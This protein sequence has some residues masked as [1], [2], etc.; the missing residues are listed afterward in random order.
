MKFGLSLF[1]L[2]ITIPVAAQ[3]GG[4]GG[5][6]PNFPERPPGDPA[7]IA[8]GRNLY[9]TNCSFCHGEDVRGGAQGGP[10]LIRS[11]FL[12]R[13]QNGEVLANIVQNGIPGTAMQKFTL[14][15][16][17]VS[18]I[19]AFIHSFG[20][21]SRDPGRNRPPSIVV[22][23]AK[24]GEA[25][26]G[27][28]CASCHSVNG[29]LKGIASRIQE[30]RTLQQTWIM[31][32]VYGG[33]GGGGTVISSASNV[34]PL[35]VTVTQA[36]GQ[37]VEGRLGRIDDFIVT[38]TEPDGTAHSF[39]RDGAS[40]KV[41]IHDPLQPHKDLL[42]IYTDKDIHDVTAYLVTIK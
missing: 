23:D 2:W 26:F 7:A 16:A 17:E 38:L 20:I 4:P 28:K 30:A 13:D 8:R 19:A 33:R 39:R 14:S 22:G 1:G 34:P 6:G 41:D 5:R 35:T 37:K 10:N 32:L 27:S 12:L 29:D 42:R 3:N 15:N 36:D 18:D 24:A 31:P 9:D 11:D 25:Y 21:S 40:P